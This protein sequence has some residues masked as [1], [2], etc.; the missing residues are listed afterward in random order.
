MAGTCAKRGGSTSPSS[1]AA[2]VTEGLDVF[3]SSPSSATG[4]AE[5]VCPVDA[6]L[7]LVPLTFREV[8]PDV[9][10]LR[11]ALPNQ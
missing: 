7:A 5:L 9:S 1:L 8:F 3:D 11:F 2:D 6:A 4:S 10:P